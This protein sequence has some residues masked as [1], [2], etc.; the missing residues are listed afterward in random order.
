MKN[1]KF[2][3][4]FLLSITGTLGL[5]TTLTSCSTNLTDRTSTSTPVADSEGIQENIQRTI[6]HIPFGQ[7]LPE[8]TVVYKGPIEQSISVG[9]SL[10]GTDIEYLGLTNDKTAQVRLDKQ[11]AIKRGGDSLTWKGN[12]VE[13]V[14]IKLS[15]RVLWYNEK[16]LQLAGTI[17][18]RVNQ[19]NPKPGPVPQIA[20]SSS[21]SFLVYKVPVIYRVKQGET[22]PGT[23]LT[24]E[25][26]TDKGAQLSGLPNDEY[27]YRQVGDSISWQGQ[28]RSNTYLDLIARTVY[29]NN[30]SLNVTGVA[31]IILAPTESIATVSR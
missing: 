27:P 5:I 9:S 26:N 19:A 4:G 24:Y 31:T 22:I 30:D 6:E 23:T 11:R 10:P 12:P 29:Y 8:G 14:E 18:L 20:D 1:R 3:I 13:G 15:D 16:R 25:G 7:R 28:L 2:S 17:R 21:S